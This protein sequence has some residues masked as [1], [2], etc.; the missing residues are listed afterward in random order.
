MTLSILTPNRDF[1]KGEITQIGLDATEGRLVIRP[2]HAPFVFSLKEGII[3]I[4]SPE[5]KQYAAVMGGFAQVKE[6]EVILLTQA[7]EWPEEIDEHRATCAKERAMERIKEK[8]QAHLLDRKRA[9][10]SLSRSEVRLK[11]MIY[12]TKK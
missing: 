7:A 10:Q 4:D 6:N 5:G 11:L 9:L 2:R 1:F 3:T 8:E 12:R